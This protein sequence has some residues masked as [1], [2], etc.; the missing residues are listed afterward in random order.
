M[1]KTYKTLNEAIDPNLPLALLV[2]S[3]SASTSEIVS[4]SL[5]DLGSCSDSRTKNIGKGLYKQHVRFLTILQMKITTAKYYIPEQSLYSGIGLHSQKWQCRK[6]SGL[7]GFLSIRG[8]E[9]RCMMEGIA[10]TLVT[11]P[12]K[13]EQHQSEFDFKNILF[14]YAT[15]VTDV[16][17]LKLLLWIIF[18]LW[19]RTSTISSLTFP[20]KNTIILPRAKKR[21]K[22]IWRRTIMKTEK[23]FQDIQNRYDA[24]KNKTRSQQTGRCWEK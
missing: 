19:I 10:S 16:C 11:E 23:Y 7:T 15:H 17:I 6:S 5:Q 12:Q 3:G 22:K 1:D 9:E 21:W 8:Q 20:I 4:G 18:E 24:L 2:N 13:A 14:D